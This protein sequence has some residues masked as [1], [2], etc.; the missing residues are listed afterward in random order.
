MDMSLIFALV[1]VFGIA[2]YVLA[3][4]FDLGIG[5]LFLLAPRDADRDLM[6]ESVAPL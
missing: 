3:D 2:V 6:M 5:I 1:I 4:G